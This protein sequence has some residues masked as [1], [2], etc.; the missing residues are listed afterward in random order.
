MSGFND[1]DDGFIPMHRFGSKE[2]KRDKE[3][4]KESHPDDS[5]AGG[6]NLAELI[7]KYK[8]NPEKAKK[9]IDNSFKAEIEASGCTPMGMFKGSKCNSCSSYSSNPSSIG[10]SSG[11]CSKYKRLKV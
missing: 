10:I 8:E 3:D 5:R 7:K 11:Y 2:W 6:D 9:D 1:N 4:W